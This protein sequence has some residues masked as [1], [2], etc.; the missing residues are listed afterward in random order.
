V[1]R[2]KFDAKSLRRSYGIFVLNMSVADCLMGV[3]MLIVGTAD[4]MYRGS[5]IWNDYSWRNGSMCEVA[6]FLSTL[7]SEASCIFITLITVD[8]LLAIKFP[9]GRIRFTKCSIA[10][11]SVITWL[12]SLVLAAIPL[13]PPFRSWGLYSQNSMCLALPLSAERAPG[14]QYSSGIFIGLNFVLFVLIGVCQALIYHAVSSSSKVAASM[15]HIVARSLFLVV[16][17]D[18]LCWFP[19]GVMGEYCTTCITEYCG[20]EYLTG[21]TQITM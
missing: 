8:R 17:T 4:L 5:Y 3:Y 10:I 19:V 20:G 9:F 21:R 2:V 15:D 16:F 7:A 13:L 11:C 18:F 12:V 14:W 1:Y 6:G